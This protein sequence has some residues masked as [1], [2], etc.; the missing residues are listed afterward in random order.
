[1]RC[2]LSRPIGSTPRK[3]EKPSSADGQLA[4]VA[5]QPAD[6]RPE[7]AGQRRDRHGHGEPRDREGARAARGVRRR[8]RR[9]R[10]RAG[11]RR[12]PRPARRR[13]GCRARPAS[14][15]GTSAV[16]EPAVQGRAR[17]GGRPWRRTPGRRRRPRPRAARRGRGRPRGRARS[18]RRCRGPAACR[19][20][21]HHRRSVVSVDRAGPAHRRFGGPSGD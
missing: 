16:A 17:T 12:R 21:C 14:T 15:P 2:A 18:A 19:P 13:C 8:P 5:V 4:L 1:M 6:P 3:A 11:V 20:P 9:G 10:P 7:P